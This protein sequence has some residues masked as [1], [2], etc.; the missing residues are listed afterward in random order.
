LRRGG[1]TG[2]RPAFL[3]RRGILLLIAVLMC[4]AAGLAAGG[5]VLFS[6]MQVSRLAQQCRQAHQAGEWSRVETLAR[7]WLRWDSENA[8][9]WIY[10]ADASQQ[11]GAFEQAAEYLNHLPDD[12]PKTV[13]ALLERTTLLFGPLNQ[14]LEGIATCQ[15]ILQINPQVL[16]ARQRLIFYYAQTMQRSEMVRQIREAIRYGTDTRE[17]YVYLIGTNYLVFSNGAE[18]NH[19][20]L[21]GVP[22]HETFLVARALHLIGTGIVGDDV[23]D[24]PEAPVVTDNRQETLKEHERIL[25]GYLDR[26]P[27]NLELLVYF[28]MKASNN[29]ESERAIQLLE[30]AP[31]EAEQD[32]R[33]WRYRGWLLSAQGQ[34]R[35]AELAYRKALELFP[36]DYS[37]HHHLAQV[38][39]QMQ[40][41]KEVDYMQDLAFRGN[42]FRKELL[43]LP[44]ARS[45]TVEQLIRIADYIEDCGD[46]PVADALR[47]RLNQVLK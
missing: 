35:E 42:E 23:S 6:K 19:H 25:A 24:E 7:Q 1:A 5:Y 36:F 17:N 21:K 40:R 4:L 43:Q 14:P 16:E 37:S 41:D 3:A 39:R 22:D 33:F 45:V 26:F 34:H 32:C 47:R 13:P 12:D 46:Q 30:Q 38:L 9:P 10:L 2:S 18:Q 27:K 31:P 44:D 20:W 11:Q 29:G 15:R 28:L 8:T